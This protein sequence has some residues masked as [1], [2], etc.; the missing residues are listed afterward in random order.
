MPKPPPAA[1][2]PTSTTTRNKTE[3]A[4]SAEAAAELASKPETGNEAQ[5]QTS[6]ELSD[7][8]AAAK[9]A[10]MADAGEGE[11]SGAGNQRG[12]RGRRGRMPRR[13]EK[14][15]APGN[16][17]KRPAP[18]R[19]D[20]VEALK[21][22]VKPKIGKIGRKAQASGAD[23]PPLPHSGCAEGRPEDS[24]AGGQ[25]RT[26]SKG[27]ALTT[28]FSLPGRYTVLMPNTPYAGGISRKITDPAERRQLREAYATLNV[29]AT[30]GLSSALPGSASRSSTSR[31][32]T[33]T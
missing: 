28:Y 20:A 10:A 24:G 33:K 13:A 2:E 29:P 30:M 14:P 27:A 5:E 32:I 18:A 16:A 31:T 6:D 23:S 12:G 8:E 15:R 19:E 9:A 4:T 1:A 11:A 3:D 22:P 26:C 17:P 21:P 25:G 7:E